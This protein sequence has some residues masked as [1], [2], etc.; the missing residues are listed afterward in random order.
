MPYSNDENLKKNVSNDIQYESSQQFFTNL[1][2][3][4]TLCK[5]SMITLDIFLKYFELAIKRSISLCCEK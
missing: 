4:Y 1:G 3:S 2:I 5:Y